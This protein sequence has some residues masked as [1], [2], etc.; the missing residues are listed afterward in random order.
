MHEVAHRF[1]LVAH[2]AVLPTIIICTF[3]HIEGRKAGLIFVLC[4]FIPFSDLRLIFNVLRP[5]RDPHHPNKANI[6]L[7]KARTR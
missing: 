6:G 1:G 3:E 4:D 7:F 5:K 2:F